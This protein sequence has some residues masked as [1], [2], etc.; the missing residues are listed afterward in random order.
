MILRAISIE[1]EEMLAA[2]GPS[3]EAPAPKKKGGLTAI[4]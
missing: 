2:D 1:Q 4:V 3:T